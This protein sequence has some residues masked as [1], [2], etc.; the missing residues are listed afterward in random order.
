MDSRLKK[1]AIG[2][3]LLAIG[4]VTL[5]VLLMNRSEPR[6]QAS[7]P[8]VSKP[9]SLPRTQGQIGDDL[10][11]F[12]K[13]ESFFDETHDTR[14]DEIIERQR[15]LSFE[16]LCLGRELRVQVWD[17]SQARVAGKDF[18]LHVT[19]LDDNLSEPVLYTD[20]DCDGYWVIE[21]LLPG[22]YDIR[23]EPIDDYIVASES[24]SVTIADAVSYE[25]MDES[26]ITV[27]DESESDAANEDRQRATAT[28]KKDDSDKTLQTG[29][30]A[31]VGVDLS[32]RSGELDF[33]KLADQGV[34]FVI[35][36]A[37][38]RGST[39]A[40]LI[41]DAAFTSNLRQAQKAGL[42]V[43]ISFGSQAINEAEAV[44]EASAVLAILDYQSVRFPIFI[45]VEQMMADEARAV[46]LSQEER[47]SVVKAFCETIEFAGYK[48]GVYASAQG[49]QS[50]V[51]A[52]SLAD[53]H[54]WLAEYKKVPTYDGYYDIWQYTSN[55]SLEG[56]DE[57][58]HFNLCYVSY[59]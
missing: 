41:Q 11:G 29:R 52:Q 33:Q 28:N 39:N 40:E 26:W 30:D 36:R 16:T 2:L 42:Y 56:I 45:D 32:S 44:E 9:P 1:R 34:E 47:T 12:L 13:D 24:I 55:G 57:T 22:N 4:L 21:D 46:N 8:T 49:L 51:E 37:G 18:T 38:Y 31:L 27:R 10:Q 53:Y 7:E 54:L 25:P 17:S 14:V 59:T 15:T 23:L 48:V 19:G 3:V 20:E 35:L 6:Q 58:L 5:F 50:D 43:G